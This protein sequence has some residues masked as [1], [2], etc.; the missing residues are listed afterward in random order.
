MKLLGE[1]K[2]CIS[3]IIPVY[4]T[5]QYLIQCIESVL[6]QSFREYEIILVDDGSGD[7]SSKICDKYAH[8]HDNIFAYHK[9]NEGLGPTRNYG[10][11]KAVG[12]YITFLDSGEIGRAHV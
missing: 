12:E 2:V 6:K 4:N 7:S 3:V 9:E 8:N 1:K 11:C 10:V 5:E